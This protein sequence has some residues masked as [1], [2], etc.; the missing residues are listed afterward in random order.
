MSL[1]HLSQ[2]SKDQH[3]ASFVS[4]V[5]ILEY[6][7]T[8]DDACL[9]VNLTHAMYTPEKDELDTVTLCMEDQLRSLGILS[10]MDDALSSTLVSKYLKGI[11]LDASTPPRK[12]FFMMKF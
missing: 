9:F 2:G 3:T 5:V 11:N 1:R 8:L 4:T 7:L 12:V 6:S 10:S